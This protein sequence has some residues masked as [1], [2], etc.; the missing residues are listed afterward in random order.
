MLWNLK[1]M[2]NDKYA[3]T[4]RSKDSNTLKVSYTECKTVQFA[5]TPGMIFDVEKIENR[6]KIVFWTTVY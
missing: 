4:R 3:G 1:R 2:M 5:I 6:Y